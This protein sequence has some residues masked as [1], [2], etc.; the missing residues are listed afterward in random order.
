MYKFIH[1]LLDPLMTAK[2]KLSLKALRMTPSMMQMCKE[3]DFSPE[4]LK[5]SGISFESMFE[6]VPIVISNS[7]LVNYL[8]CEIEEVLPPVKDSFLDLSSGVVIEKNLRLLVEYVDDLTQDNNKYFTYQRQ[9]AK[10]NQ[11]KQQLLAKRQQEN[12]LRHDRGEAPIPDDDIHKALKPPPV[13]SRLDSLL[14]SSQIASYC[15]QL[16]DTT[17]QNLGKLFVVDSINSSFN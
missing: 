12:K 10:Q 14:L 5:A 2:G 7:H 11:N 15:D 4:V 8:F 16:V 9:V 3:M 6:E 17:N 13:P 1:L